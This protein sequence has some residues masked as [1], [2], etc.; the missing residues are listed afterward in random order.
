MLMATD[1]DVIKLFVKLLPV[2]IIVGVISLVWS[3]MSSAW[4]RVSQTSALQFIS[5]TLGW[6]NLLI[7]IVAVIVVGYILKLISKSKKRKQKEEE[8]RRLADE[9][10]QFYLELYGDVDVVDRIIAKELWIGETTK[11]LEYSLGHPE[12]IERK[13]LKTKTKETW[14]YDRKGVNRYG[15]R[16]Y[17][18]NGEVVGWEN[19]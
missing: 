3:L 15:T 13:V 1:S 11:Q 12:D 18:E 19:K 10:Y 17:V 8:R 9:R 16:V 5:Q 14:K 4:E 2:I 7:L 6:T